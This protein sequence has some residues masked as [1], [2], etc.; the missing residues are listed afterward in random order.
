MR[1][2]QLYLLP[3]KVRINLQ[4]ICSKRR[5]Q[6]TYCSPRTNKC[7]EP[8]KPRNTIS[9][10]SDVFV[11]STK[12]A[13]LLIFICWKLYEWIFKLLRLEI[14][15]RQGTDLRS[16]FLHCKVNSSWSNILKVYLRSP[17]SQGPVTGFDL[18][19]LCFLILILWYL[20][21][22]MTNKNSRKVNN[23]YFIARS[24]I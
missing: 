23:I 3:M 4:D 15:N 13:C 2:I 21:I 20:N 7:R 11:F 14:M 9:A 10:I 1:W 12:L 8:N 16:R 6:D 17:R 22:F 24:K 19:I 18:K 5:A